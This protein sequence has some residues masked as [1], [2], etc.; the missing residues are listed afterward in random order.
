MEERSATDPYTMGVGVFVI[1]VRDGALKFLAGLRA[2]TVKRS[3]NVWGLPGGMMDPGESA[4]KC[5]IRETKEETGLDLDF[6]ESN[7]DPEF[8]HPLL[9]VSDHR[10][11]DN[12]LTFWIAGW[13]EP[14]KEPTLMEPTKHVCWEW[15]TPS[16][17]FDRVPQVGDQVYWSP[18][19]TWSI[20]LRRVGF[21]EF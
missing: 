1:T 2:P 8:E 19:S 21:G 15:F 4:R 6:D 9:G 16:E 20:M 12:H 3:P 5:A 7:A 18:K 10:P 11:R 14:G 13:V 17:F